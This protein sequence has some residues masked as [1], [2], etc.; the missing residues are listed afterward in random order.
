MPMIVA[1]AIIGGAI[2]AGSLIVNSALSEMSAELSSIKVA[3]AQTRE[4]LEEV[5][6]SRPAAAPAQ[7]RRRGPD[8]D[9]RHTINTAGAPAKGPPSAK[10]HIVEFSDFQ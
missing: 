6:K 3:L 4:S 2:L 5:A 9:K 7:Q 10:V 8:P 1:A